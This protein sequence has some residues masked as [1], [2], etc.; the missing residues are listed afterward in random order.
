MDGSRVL[1]KDL[2]M[3]ALHR[4]ARIEDVVDQQHVLAGNLGFQG[5]QNS[6]SRFRIS[7]VPVTGYPY[8]VQSQRNAQVA[9]E[10]GGEDNGSVKQGDEQDFL[11]LV[12]TVDLK[13]QLGYA[14]TDFVFGKK[15][16]LEIVFQG[17]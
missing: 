2:V 17:I 4:V 12:M 10:V 14:L 16:L 5:T 9:N 3:H 1:G 15:N 8:A 7:R 13:P 6:G 11:P